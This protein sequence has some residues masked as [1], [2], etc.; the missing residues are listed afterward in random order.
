MHLFS[1]QL[2]NANIKIGLFEIK[3]SLRK[4]LFTVNCQYTKPKNAKLAI[5]SQLSIAI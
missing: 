3:Y 4:R 5:Y 2:D 1:L